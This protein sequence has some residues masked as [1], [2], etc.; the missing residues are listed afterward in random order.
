M[1]KIKH[2]QYEYETTL[3]LSFHDCDAMGIVWHG[4]Y[5]K[6]FEIAREGLLA[7][8][9]IDYQS[10]HESGFIYPVIEQQIRYRKAISVYS[11]TVRVRAYLQEIFNRIKLGYEVFDDQHQLCAFG[12]TIQV[13]VQEGS[14]ELN[15]VTPGSFVSHFADFKEN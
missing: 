15:M 12:Y 1:H 9:G 10:M 3:P 8:H 6:F 7:E 5:L 2:Y 14:E 11:K 4:N 13:A